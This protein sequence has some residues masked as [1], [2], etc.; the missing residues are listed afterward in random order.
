MTEADRPWGPDGEY[1]PPAAAVRAKV[2]ARNAD[3]RQGLPDTGSTKATIRLS[4]PATNRKARRA[5]EAAHRRSK[6]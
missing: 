6:K 1:T 5:H 4:N 3:R 2:K